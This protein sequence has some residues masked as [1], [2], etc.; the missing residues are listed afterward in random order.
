[1]MWLNAYF[2]RQSVSFSLKFSL[3]LAPVSCPIPTP[4]PIGP[5]K[6]SALADWFLYLKS[7]PRAQLTHRPDD[8]RSKDL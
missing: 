2:V 4:F 8:G 7:I 6:V 1:M 5:V 3:L